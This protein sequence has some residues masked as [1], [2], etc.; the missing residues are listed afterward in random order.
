MYPQYQQWFTKLLPYNFTIKFKARKV[1]IIID[2]LSRVNLPT[3]LQVI[4]IQHPSLIDLQQ[5]KR[6]VEENPKIA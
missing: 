1:N 6:E 2:V 3:N 4:T 5:M